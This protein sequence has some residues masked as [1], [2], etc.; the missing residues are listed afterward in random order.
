MSFIAPGLLGALCAG[1]GVSSP[2]GPGNRLLW[3]SAD[4]TGGT[5]W[6]NEACTIPAGIGSRVRA[7]KSAEGTIF[8]QPD[9]GQAPLLQGG[10]QNGLSGLFFSDSRD[11]Y[12]GMTD[13][14]FLATLKAAAQI[15]I[16]LVWKYQSGSGEHNGV[17]FRV[18]GGSGGLGIRRNPATKTEA[19]RYGT[20]D[21]LTSYTSG[22]AITAS[23]SVLLSSDGI[24]G[25]PKQNRVYVQTTANTGAS[26]TDST[27]GAAW[28]DG[29]LGANRASSGHTNFLTGYIFEIAIFDA[30]ADLTQAGSLFSYATAKWGL[31]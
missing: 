30:A 18:R 16:L 1:G 4:G 15:T 26:N 3:W 28:T 6:E 23:H 2:P 14:A 13:A 31:P 25:S 20:G 5:T 17:Q 27:D 21:T 19:G 10:V 24:G 12:L 22:S 7:V 9:A 11:D 29:T 8:T